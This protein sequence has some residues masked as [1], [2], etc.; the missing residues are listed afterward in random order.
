MIS[1][2]GDPVHGLQKLIAAILVLTTMDPSRLFLTGDPG[3]GKTTVV[4]RVCEI[5]ISQGRKVGGMISREIRDGGV[6]VGF[7]MEDVLSHEHGI[8][9]HIRQNE[10]PRVGK[11]R[12]NLA[13]IERVGVAAITRAIT[14]ADLIVVDEVGPMELNSQP[15]ILAVEKALGSPKHF[16]GTIH[17]HASHYLVTAIKSNQAYRILEVTREN[18]QELPGKIA[19]HLTP[20]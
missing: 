20:A 13:D 2:A 6:R 12:V 19:E 10:G 7:G 5:L 15:F 3:C 14:D 1:S 17:K 4:R 8:L 18:R 16:V 11:Y 9:A